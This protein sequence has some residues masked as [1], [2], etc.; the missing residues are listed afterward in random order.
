MQSL[1]LRLRKYLIKIPLSTFDLQDFAQK[2]KIPYFRGVFMKNSLP[3][4]LLLNESGIVNLDVS[5]GSGTH[6]VCYYTIGSLV[7][8]Y[9][10]LLLHLQ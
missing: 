3:K 6:W 4:N 2:L 10:T 7:D 1:I 8:Y 9:D 5:S